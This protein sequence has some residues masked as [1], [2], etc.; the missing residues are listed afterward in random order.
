M[1][2]VDELEHRGLAGN[3]MVSLRIDDCLQDSVKPQ[4][5]WY[6]PKQSGF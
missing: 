2:W 3:P 6:H 5:S 1:L 4:D